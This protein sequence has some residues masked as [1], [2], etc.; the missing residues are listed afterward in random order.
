MLF[1]VFF[2]CFG[3]LIGLCLTHPLCVGDVAGCV[4]DAGEHS[5]EAVGIEV[6]SICYIGAYCRARL[7]LNRAFPQLA[8][9]AA[10][11]AANSGDGNDDEQEEASPVMHPSWKILVFSSENEIIATTL[12]A[13]EPGQGPK[14][15]AFF[16]LRFDRY[17]DE[18]QEAEGKRN[19]SA[20]EGAIFVSAFVNEIG[21]G[22]FAQLIVNSTVSTST[23]AVM[24]KP[25]TI[26][27]LPRMM[28]LGETRRAV[29]VFHKQVKAGIFFMGTGTFPHTEVKVKP[30]DIVRTRKLELQTWCDFELVPSAVGNYTVSFEIATKDRAVPHFS[31]TGFLEVREKKAAEKKRK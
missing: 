9:P 11:A 23:K 20:K 5:F 17:F 28:R 13:F 27:N 2:I 30:C 18:K 24:P 22:E 29:I 21:T 3:A 4:A 10:A 6:E 31:E 12:V 1:C 25:V 8:T 26:E 16:T 15:D 14:K 19:P 7:A